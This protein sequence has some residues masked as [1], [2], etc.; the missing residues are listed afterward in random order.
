[1][2]KCP[3]CEA[4]LFPPEKHNLFVDCSACGKS[5]YVVKTKTGWEGS[6]TPQKKYKEKPKTSLAVE[7][8]KIKTEIEK[9]RIKTE[10]EPA[11]EE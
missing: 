4:K 2:V 1:M 8:P 7:S 3:Y 10:I 9:P 5:F 11:V 6:K